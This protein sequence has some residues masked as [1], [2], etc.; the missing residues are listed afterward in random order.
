[1]RGPALAPCGPKSTELLLYPALPFIRKPPLLKAPLP[2]ETQSGLPMPS[3]E[4]SPVVGIVARAFLP[5]GVDGQ[6]SAKLFPMPESLEEPPTS[7]PLPWP[8]SLMLLTSV[9]ESLAPE[10]S[11]SKMRGLGCL[12]SCSE[13]AK[14]HTGRRQL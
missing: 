11:S 14:K 10:E 6:S 12:K 8:D 4:T 5:G 3:I 7:L 13:W 2:S 1:M 9:F